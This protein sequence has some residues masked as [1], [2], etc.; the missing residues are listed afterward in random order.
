MDLRTM[1]EWAGEIGVLATILG[2]FW[3]GSWGFRRLSPASRPGDV[4]G[5]PEAG[6]MGIV[7]IIFGALILF[8]GPFV[9]DLSRPGQWQPWVLLWAS[10]ISVGVWMLNGALGVRARFNRSGVEVR[11][12]RGR[13]RRYAWRQIRRVRRDWSNSG[14]V[15]VFEDRSKFNLWP[16][17]VGSI[18]LLEAARDAD[19]PGTAELFIP[20]GER[21]RR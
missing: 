4:L 13:W 6:G 18:E 9:S 8:G 1:P 14:V 21:K 5:Y 11:D 12:W 2:L 7:S 10:F 3:L 16:G 20:P 17:M 19:V 15:L